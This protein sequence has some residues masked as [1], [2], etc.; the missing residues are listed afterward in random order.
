[1][2]GW[3]LPGIFSALADEQKEGI[4]LLWVNSKSAEGGRTLMPA[5]ASVRSEALPFPTRKLLYGAAGLFAF[6]VLP[7]LIWPALA[8]RVLASNFLPHLYCYLAKPGLVWT[9]VVADSLIALSYLTISGTL[10]FLVQKGHRDI[11]FHWMF[12]A[13]GL[14]IVACGGTHFMEVVTVWVPVYVLSAS[15]K[16]FTALVSVTTAVLLPF[17][18]PQ[19]LSLVQTAKASEAA[20]G[21]FRDL[22]EA[23]PDA[24]VVV[25]QAGKIVLINTQT[26]KMFGYKREEV[27]GREMEALVPERFREQHRGHRMNFSAEPRV[28]PMG[29]KLELAGL[30]KGGT[31]FPVEVSLSPIETEEGIL[32]TSAIR[33]ITERKRA[34]AALASVSRRLIQAQE[35]ERTRIARELHDDIVQRLALLAIRLEQVQ[36]NSPDLTA[37]SRTRMVELR[38]QTSEIANEI[39]S[40][41]HELHSAKLEYLG[42]AAAMKGFCKEFS[43][44]QKVEVDFKAFDL[45]SALPPDFSLCFFR[46]LQEALRNAA[47]HS[48]ASHFEVRLWGTSGEIH[49]TVRDS[50]A[51][52]DSAAAKEG[53]GI[54]LIS[55][56]ERLKLLNG[57]FSIESRPQS[58]TTIHARLPLSSQSDSVPIAAG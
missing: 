25:D 9:H 50:G 51:G 49:L 19:I 32:I 5:I 42:I 18:V 53:R 13:F 6:A 34:E 33:D 15:L 43:E 48:G 58:G 37:E 4:R 29:A 12:L 44:R 56:E 22:L 21:R 28:R 39:Q 47:K 36:Q 3:R 7:F 46:V 35:Q 26:E 10:G 45:P 20:E 14:F 27:L 57:T 2:P 40:L 31:E 17:T 1:M 30:R 8:D 52:F 24:M 54:G 11:P 41:S 38:N 55:M 16:V 23:A